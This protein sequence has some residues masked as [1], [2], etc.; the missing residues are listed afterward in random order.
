MW[1]EGGGYEWDGVE[2]GGKELKH[3]NHGNEKV[4]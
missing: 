3:G 4:H 1:M 2:E